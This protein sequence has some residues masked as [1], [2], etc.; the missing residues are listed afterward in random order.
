[1]TSPM[2]V[3]VCEIRFEGCIFQVQHFLHEFNVMILLGQIRPHF[4]GLPCGSA[5]VFGYKMAEAMR[6]NISGSKRNRRKCRGQESKFACFKRLIS[7]SEKDV[8]YFANS[9]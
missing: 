8:K 4:L 6:D 2:G 3:L 5:I 1:M 9:A 7:E